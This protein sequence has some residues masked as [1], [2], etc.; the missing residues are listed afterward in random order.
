MTRPQK[1]HEP[2]EADFENVLSTIADEQKPEIKT[3][4]ARP[5]LKWVGGKRSILPELLDRMPKEYAR[6]YEPFLGGGALFFAVQPKKA[7]LSDINFHLI[8]TFQ[9]VRD[10][11]DRVIAQL[12][13]LENKHSKE[14]YQKARLLLF[15]DPVL[16]AALFIY[17]NKTCYNGLY[18]VNKSGFFNVP[19][20]DYKTPA[21]VDEDNLWACCKLLEGKDIT[22]QNFDQLKPRIGDFYYLDPPYHETYSGYSGGGFGDNEHIAL[23]AFA[24]RID[25]KGA[26]FMLS[27]SDTPFVRKLYKGYTIEKVSASRMVSCKGDGRGK[28]NELIIRNYDGRGQG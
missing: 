6:Y 24:K 2:I 1:I 8:V 4:T 15:E 21:I 9:A 16:I 25:E 22:Q 7:F 18:R 14:F 23:A 27:N 3:A 11:V 26:K 5:F 17:L 20:G 28:E 19:M 13:N 12:K 10:H